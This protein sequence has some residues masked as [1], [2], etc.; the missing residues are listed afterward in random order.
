MDLIFKSFLRKINENLTQNNGPSYDR[1]SFNFAGKGGHFLARTEVSIT[2]AL[3]NCQTS[4]SHLKK[5]AY[6]Y[7]QIYWKKLKVIVKNFNILSRSP[8]N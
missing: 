5:S 6:E 4:S 7:S 1:N 3:H 8:V 2:S